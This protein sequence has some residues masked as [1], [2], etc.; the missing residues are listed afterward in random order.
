MERFK[1]FLALLQDCTL[2]FSTCTTLHLHHCPSQDRCPM[3]TCTVTWVLCP[4]SLPTATHSS[5][6]Q[7]LT[8][9]PPQ[10]F[11]AALSTQ[12]CRAH[13]RVSCSCNRRKR[14]AC[15][16]HEEVRHRAAKVKSFH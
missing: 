1:L 7:R 12:P 8:E 11:R 15:C 3:Q 4:P 6:T 13:G 10:P 2:A 5:Y 9:F 14:Q 16:T